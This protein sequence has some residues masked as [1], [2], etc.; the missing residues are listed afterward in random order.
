MHLSILAFA[1]ITLLGSFSPHPAHA[2]TEIVPYST[3]RPLMEWVSNKT[4]IFIQFVPAVFVS[5]EMM[6]AK[7]GDPQRLSAMARALYVPNQVVIDEEFWD[8]EDTRTVSF[9][10]HELVHHAQY[11]SGKRYQCNNAK[12]WEAYRLQ[13]EWLAEQGLD[14]AVDEEWIAHM[15]DCNNHY[16]NFKK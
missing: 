9:L 14:A 5:R 4:G 1:F 13:N 7:I 10:L 8:A 16:V 3:V 12:E 6:V 11:V 2:G 15:A